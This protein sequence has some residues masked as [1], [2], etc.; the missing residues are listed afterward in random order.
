MILDCMLAFLGDL[1]AVVK[2][3]EISQDRKIPNRTYPGRLYI[4]END[5]GSDRD[6][7]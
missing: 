4:T 1:V 3:N 2:E 5:Q 6:G 7:S